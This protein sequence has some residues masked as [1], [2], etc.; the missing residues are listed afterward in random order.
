MNKTP[1]F[2]KQYTF[3]DIR[4]LFYEKCIEKLHIMRIQCEVCAC[5][6]HIITESIYMAEIHFL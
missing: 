3:I 2:M 5:K 1:S 4:I 6:E